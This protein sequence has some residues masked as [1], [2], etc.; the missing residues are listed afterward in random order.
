MVCPYI[1]RRL[2]E[3]FLFA[4]VPVL[5]SA[6]TNLIS[7]A[8]FE[9]SVGGAPASWT[10]D[11]QS[12]GGF[13]G[14][15]T[16]GRH[17]GNGSLTLSWTPPVASN[18]VGMGSLGVAQALS[19]TALSGKTL[20]ASGWLSADGQATAVLTVLA[21]RS[22]GS[23]YLTQMRQDVT[24]T[25]V[26]VRDKLVIPDDP[27]V[28]F[29]LVLC[30][31][32]GSG[33]AHFDD[34][35]VT[36]TQPLDWPVDSSVSEVPGQ[37]ISAQVTVNAQSVIRAVPPTL[38]GQNLE[39]I[40]NGNGAWDAVQNRPAPAVAS[41]TRELNT[42]LLR[43][44]G[45]IMADYY[46][47]TKA[48]GP[49]AQRPIL[50]SMPGGA[51]EK[52]YFGTDEALQFASSVGAELLITVNAGSGTAQM[53]AD[54]VRYVNKS[55]LNVRYWEIGN[56]LYGVSGPMFAPVTLPPAQYAAKVVEFAR[57]M[58]QADPRIQ[59]GAIACESIST[60]D[61]PTYPL[62]TQ[63]VLETAANDI[64][65]LAVHNSY[66]PGVD[67]DLGLSTTSTY[68]SM[69]AAP[70]NIRRSL[71]N[72]DRKVA[73]YA[74]GRVDAIK[75]AVT[76]WGPYFSANPYSRFAEHTKT[77][78]SAVYVASVMKVFLESKN[79]EVAN[80]F[81]LVDGLFTGWI[82]MRNGQYTPKA[83]YY[84]LQLFSR[85]FGDLVVSTNTVSPTFDTLSL[86]TVPASSDVPYVESV[87][88]KSTDGKT[89]YVA[90]WNKSP[91][92]AANVTCVIQ[93]FMPSGVIETRSLTGTAA[94]AHTGTQPLPGV[95]LAPQAVMEGR[96]DFNSGTDSHVSMP[97][98]LSTASGPNLSVTV[99][100]MSIVMLKMSGQ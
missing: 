90:I 13:A 94:D 54:W 82:G 66:A 55:G 32:E 22:N 84:A 80:A 68:M 69:L 100:P 65:F 23:V 16:V 34:L 29:G 30:Q 21:Y 36:L 38:F 51:V 42:K 76:E 46:D 52:P 12:Q 25:P 17:G 93:D 47:W 3:F 18:N 5:A 11:N 39:W 98:S 92:R 87:A 78:A 20:Y 96:S 33:A 44:P 41:L 50:E 81:Q 4:V 72:L 85:Y 31:M 86:G 97:V 28:I 74:P 60:L 59:I 61:C 35:S 83:S 95:P 8:G 43:F 70:Q 48:V 91:V 19:T 58:R 89:L 49:V 27:L 57:A 10:I 15:S 56:E 24:A 7:N 45:G 2:R 37:V 75:V 88:S 9:Q 77:M 64:D 63:T 6:Q 71:E 53:A 99:P 67:V 40:W 73:T 79:T 26:Q 62:W 14:L 1:Q